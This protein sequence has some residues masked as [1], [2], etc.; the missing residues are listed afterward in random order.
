MTLT[1][2]IGPEDL[3]AR[4]VA[5]HTLIDAGALTDRLRRAGADVR[6]VC[7]L[8]RTL[9]PEPPAGLSYPVPDV[10]LDVPVRL[11]DQRADGISS[12]GQLSKE[13]ARIATDGTVHAVGWRATAVAVTARSITGV[14]VVGH[15]DQLPSVPGDDRVDGSVMARLG[16]ATLAA[17]DHVVVE[18]AWAR[19]IAARRGVPL[20]MTSVVGP[21]LAVV[22]G[23][24]PTSQRRGQDPALVLSVG[25]PADVG[26]LR[27]V[28]EAVLHHPGSRLLVARGTG[29]DARC[30]AMVKERL[31]E[32]PVVRRLGSRCKV[33]N[34]PA[35]GLCAGADLVVDV[36]ARAGR[37]LG[38]LSA[39]FEAR[40]VVASSVGGADEMVVD[41][42]TGLLVEPRDR[43]HTRDAVGDLLVDPFRLEAYGLAGRERAQA[44][45]HPDALAE[46]VLAVHSAVA[47][48]STEVV[49]VTDGAMAARAAVSLG[50]TGG[51][52]G[53]RVSPGVRSP[54]SVHA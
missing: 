35:V 24:S 8:D 22:P 40:A 23:G 15:A 11:S 36:S 14:P 42:V 16:W 19:T 53:A 32:L 39:M 1:V 18:S 51:P 9:L 5:A 41:R 45:Y 49:D 25:D 38:V 12:A 30:A 47:A 33:A 26:A 21:A 27:P 48:G 17:A 6:L 29:L 52:A 20:V 37:G 31:R 50:G 54:E 13:L 7:A 10:V 43:I 28:A 4:S 2:L 3:R 44:V 46:Q 34:D